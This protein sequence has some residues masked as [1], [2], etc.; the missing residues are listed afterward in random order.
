MGK[1]KA[2]LT[3]MT[4][5]I[6]GCDERKSVA[7]AKIIEARTRFEGLEIEVGSVNRRMKLNQGNLDAAR[8]RKNET[9]S[10]LAQTQE[11][12][13]NI[14]KSREELERNENEGDEKIQSL[15][16]QVKEIRQQ[17]EEK[18]SKLREHQRKDVVVQRD[19]ERVTTQAKSLERRCEV[20]S[21]TINNAR[22]SLAE[23]EEREG[24]ASTEEERHE[25]EQLLL[26]GQLREAEVACDAADQSLKSIERS[27]RETDQEIELWKGKTDELQRQ[28][29]EMD[30]LE[31]DSDIEE[32]R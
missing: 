24:Q 17:L 12:S 9:K 8:T 26:E 32:G 15:E 20:L 2:K 19:I 29:N 11:E 5:N 4:L 21:D 6:E 23:L 7:K 14:D 27:I 1:L 30:D 13:S 18:N 22:E 16:E 28:L 10:R 3:E 31:V 25:E